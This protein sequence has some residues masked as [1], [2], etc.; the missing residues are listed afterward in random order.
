MKKINKLFLSVCT[1]L[2]SVST[3]VGCGGNSSEAGGPT[4]VNFWGWGDPDEVEVFTKI[5]NTFNDK[6]KGQIKVN[7][8]QRPSGSYADT[9]L[10]QLNG[11]KGPDVY[12]VQDKFIKQYATLGYCADLTDYVKNSTYTTKLDESDMFSDILSRYRYDTVTTTS[13]SDDP[14]W[15]VPKDIAPTA[16]F[17]NKTHFKNA[18][19][20]CIS[21]PEETMKANGDIVKAYDILISLDGYKDSESKAASIYD[22]Y[23]IE[24]IKTAKVGDIVTF[25][26]YEQ[27]NKTSN[28][29]EK[30]EWIVLDINDGRVLVVSKYA[31]DARE[32]DSHLGYFNTWD[33]CT[34]REWLN[35]EFINESFS[36]SEKELIPTVTV[37][38]DNNPQYSTDPGNNTQDKIFLLSIAEVEKYFSSTRERMCQLTAYAK[39][40]GGYDPEQNYAY[41]GYTIWWLRTPGS[42]EEKVSAVYFDGTYSHYQSCRHD[43]DDV[44]V[45]PAMWI[46]LND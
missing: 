41:A 2:A 5:V 44:T 21:I 15:A 10:V 39:A 13:N 26:K 25:G 22:Q 33:K 7:Y 12:Y 8:T 19:I 27:D 6:Y 9:L 34:L 20:T 23:K 11:K 14:L 38:A 24:K 18:G 35:D 4:E 46:D 43:N 16:V 3:L 28:G 45:R 17:Y 42:G 32:Y 37:S 30:I 36:T 40:N 31:L 29:K 1:I